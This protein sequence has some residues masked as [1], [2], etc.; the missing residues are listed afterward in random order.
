VGLLDAL[1]SNNDLGG[2]L[3]GGLPSAWQYQNPAD[4]IRRKQQPEITYDPMGN[5]TGQSVPADPFGPLPAFSPPQP[6]SP[7]SPFGPIPAFNPSQAPSVPA[8]GIG[9]LGGGLSGPIPGMI[10]PQSAPVAQPQ[11]PAPAAA[12]PQVA[13][14]APPPQ[15]NPINMM[16]IGGYQM[17]QFGS[18]GEYTQQPATGRISTDFSAQSRQ[19]QDPQNLPPALAGLPTG[20]FLDKVNAGLQSLGHGGSIIGAL[21]GNRTDPQS[22][23]QQNLAGQYQAVRQTLL[24][25]GLSPQEA[26]SKAMLAVMNPEAGKT[27]LTEALTNREKWGEVGTD[28]LGNKQMGFINERDQTVN[29]RPLGAEGASSS[30]SAGAFLAPGVKQV[31]SSLKGSEYLAQFSPEVQQAAKDYVAGKAMPTGNPRKGFT[32]TV[33]MIA[34]KY[35]ADIG[36]SVDDATYSARRTMRNQLSSSAPSSL[37]GQINIG[38]TAA[39][40]LADLTQKALELGNVDTGIAPLTAAVNGV[41]GLGTEQAA[42]MEALKGAAQHYGQE[43][44]KF[45]AGSPGGTAERD[46]FIESVN[47]AR[48]PK[49]LAAILAT[50]GELMRSR[51]DALGGQIRG[52][53]GEEGAKEYP[54]LRSDGQAALA[55]VEAN[56]SRLRAG[57]GAAPSG[58]IPSGWSVKVN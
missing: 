47:G 51:L 36:E 35:G 11:P 48:S 56:V 30:G 46:R 45:Y 8:A 32:Q 53:L 58:G 13:A 26:N 20:N 6:V 44:T 18:V 34:R 38:N 22:I 24:Q 33:Q 7:S 25:S 19:P 21:T 55:K 39:G 12:P 16:D 41:R 37:G 42:K 17:P 52:V 5:V 2:G 1:F 28:A 43:I 54:V 50:E 49:E 29:G 3:L 4:E 10:V 57:Q 40:H 9:S 23:A 14:T 27:I 15:N 31:D